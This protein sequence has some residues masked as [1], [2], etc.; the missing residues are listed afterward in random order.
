MTKL[1]CE[2]NDKHIKSCSVAFTISINKTS[3]SHAKRKDIDSQNVLAFKDG[4]L[5]TWFKRKFQTL[6]PTKFCLSLS[7][8]TLNQVS[9]RFASSLEN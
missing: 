2:Q 1:S 8:R 5:S 6:N 4:I 3:V 9:V 7:L